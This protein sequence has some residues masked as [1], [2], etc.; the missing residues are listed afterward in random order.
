M[1][2]Q[3]GLDPL[4]TG[5]SKPVLSHVRTTPCTL[6]YFKWL[7]MDFRCVNVSLQEVMQY[8]VQPCLSLAVAR[9]R[10]PVI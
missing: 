10:T 6:Y 4:N 9:Y 5:I 2:A 7:T 1:S 3:T 8:M